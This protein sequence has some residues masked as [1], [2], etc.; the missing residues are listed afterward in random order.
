MDDIKN[1]DS[2]TR[3]RDEALARQM[4]EALDRLAPAGNGE[5]PDAELIAAYHERTLQA[6]ENT[7]CENHFASCQRCRKILS[8]LAASADASLS[9]QEVARLGQLVAGKEHPSFVEIPRREMQNQSKQ[10]DWRVHWLAPALGIAAVLAMWFAVRPPWRS[11]SPSENLI[12]QAPKSEPLPAADALAEPKFSAEETPPAAPPPTAP[13]VNSIA[14]RAEVEHLPEKAGLDKAELPEA[15]KDFAYSDTL[16]TRTPGAAPALPAPSASGALQAANE[17]PNAKAMAASADSNSPMRDGHAPGELVT[18][19]AKSG[20]GAAAESS[21]ARRGDQPL[22]S[23]LGG[24]NIPQVT[25]PTPSGKILWRVGKGAPIQRSTDSGRTWTAQSSL[26]QQDWTGG[27]APSEAV[28][29]LVGRNG[30]IARTTD[31]EHWAPIAP[32]APVPG[33]APQSSDWVSV[34]A[35]SAQDAT[36][37]SGNQKRYRTQD[38]GQTWQLLP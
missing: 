3:R 19:A 8:V 10:I 14:P 5:C 31:G 6:N 4:G 27:A 1:S 18:G 16:K 20:T 7:Q 9:E 24:L 11:T 29:W 28:C 33:G 17:A 35:A 36:I 38:G 30:A 15:K 32:P 37:T 12:A 23:A 13:P 22:S 2:K 26:T 21:T 34:V 25:I